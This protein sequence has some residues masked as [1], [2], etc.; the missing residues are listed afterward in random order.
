MSSN[1][2]TMPFKSKLV[3]PHVV[4]MSSELLKGHILVG[5]SVR[6][7]LRPRVHQILGLSLPE[8]FPQV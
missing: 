6:H 3:F 8:T 4:T 1:V 2:Y 7:N 5:K